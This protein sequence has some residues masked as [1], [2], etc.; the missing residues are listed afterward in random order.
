[1]INYIQNTDRAYST[2]LDV[3]DACLIAG[4]QPCDTAVQGWFLYLINTGC[5][6]E[7]IFTVVICNLSQCII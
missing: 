3:L 7:I 2:S 5:K 4:I 1:M 6:K